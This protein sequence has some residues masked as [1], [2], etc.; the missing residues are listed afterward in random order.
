MLKKYYESEKLNDAIERGLSKYYS[1]KNSRHQYL[2]GHTIIEFIQF[3]LAL[4]DPID[5]GDVDDDR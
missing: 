1:S 3:E 2:S 5:K 4:L